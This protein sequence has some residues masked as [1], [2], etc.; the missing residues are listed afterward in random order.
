M[1][2]RVLCEVNGNELIS[3]IKKVKFAKGKKE[4]ERY[5]EIYNTVWLVC[6]KSLGRVE[7]AC[8]SGE[9]LAL[10]II[11]N[12][13]V[14]EDFKVA[15]YYDKDLQLED[16]EYELIYEDSKVKVG[17]RVLS[18]FST[19]GIPNYWKIL[20]DDAKL[21]VIC[22]PKKLL[23]TLKKVAM[24]DENGKIL[25]DLKISKNDYCKIESAKGLV[26][27]VAVNV[28]K[29]VG[30]R[31]KP[32]YIKIDANYLLKALPKFDTTQIELD[33]VDYGLPVKIFGENFL[34][35]F[36]SENFEKTKK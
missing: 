16:R 20:E 31:Q 36:V 30:Y 34:Y 26:E 35:V 9:Q 4:K 23:A 32:F 17:N 15:F 2:G 12:A 1:S 11:K 8:S 13:K 28:I 27:K 19:D 3:A 5:Y 25:V 33:F 21:K 29:W 22:N 10:Q 14:Y 18:I 6:D 7:V 24:K